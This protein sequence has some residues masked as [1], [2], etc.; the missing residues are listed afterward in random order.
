[1]NL[2]TEPWIPV[3]SAGG[4]FRTASLT[5]L[6][7]QSEQIRDLAVRPPERV[8]LMRL[9]ICIVQAAL[10]GPVERDDWEKRRPAIVPESLKYLDRWLSSFELFGERQR[11]LQVTGLKKSGMDDE[12][13]NLVS[14]LDFA[15]ATGNNSTLF[16]NAGGSERTFTPAELA[17]MLVTFQCFSPGGRIGVAAWNGQVTGNGSSNHA[18]CL[19]GGMVHA[20][21]RGE[22]LIAT[23]HRNLIT[24]KHSTE[25][26]GKDAWGTPV[27]EWMP[28]GFNDFASVQ[29]ATCT[30]LGRL[31]PLA[32]AICLNDD[33]Q[34]LVL[35]NGLEYPAYDDGWREPSATVVVRQVKN[36]EERVVLRASIEKSVWRELNAL[37]VKTLGQK[38]G[39][40]AALQNI[41]EDEKAFDIWVGGLVSDQSKIIDT[42]ESVFHIPASMLQETSQRI[43][44][45]GVKFAQ[46]AEA[47]LKQAVLSYHKEVG[48][49]LDKPADRDRRNRI[50][51]KATAH[52]WTEIEVSLARLLEVAENPDKLGTNG[53]WKNTDWGKSVSSAARGSFEHACPHE[54]ARQ[55]RAYALG[56]K[57]LFRASVEKAPVENQQEVE[58]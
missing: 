52:F 58:A 20:L 34:S 37:T 43:Y 56:L 3:V 19:S 18:P 46:G 27:W 13:G 33:C 30:Y 47:R 21:L 40:P 57:Q 42:T 36:S 53:D 49:K 15:L 54:T 25:L 48:E 55:I 38:P 14:K 28:L 4:Q 11:F 50:Q 51:S 10:D 1:M 2:A 17:L 6:F 23:I 16:D 44:E 32:R 8:A 5:E 29:N 31:V 35:A 26:F 24:K 7:E 41:S 39:G 22:D 9:F 12:E 45:L